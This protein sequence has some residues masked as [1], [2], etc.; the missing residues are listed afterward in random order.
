[1]LEAQGITLRLGGTEVLRDV[2]LALAPGEVLALV[3]PN[4]AGKSSLLGCLSG[5][6]APHRGHVRIDG[7][8]PAR[9]SAAALARRRAVLEQTPDSAAAFPLEVLVGLAIPRAVPPA[10]AA[11][12]AADA[13]T[14]MGLAHLRR[15]PLDRLSGGER[16]RAH[17]ARAL[18][19]LAAGRGLGAGRWLLLDEPTASLDPAH[20]AAVL[21][22]ARGV[23][24]E[25]AGVLA[26]LHDLTLAAALADRVALLRAGRIVATGRPGAVLTPKLLADVYGLPMSVL[27]VAGGPITITPDYHATPEGER[28]CSSQ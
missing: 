11:A 1:M 26:V 14:T 20:Q 16:H 23:A 5:A 7:D 8:D 4:G 24:G 10:E 15:R 3:G 2:D 12:L 9:L 13:M 18:A 19:Q 22:A 17:M 27:R 28:A 25:G 21:R 6:F